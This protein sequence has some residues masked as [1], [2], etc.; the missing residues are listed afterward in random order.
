MSN[1]DLYKDLL[2]LPPSTK[3]LQIVHEDAMVATVYKITQDNGPEYILKICDRENDYFR[4]V[5]FLEYFANIIPISRI[6]EKVPPAQNVS[7]AILMEF[8]PGDLLKISNLTNDLAYTIG[9]CLAKIQQPATNLTPEPHH[10]F[11][12][13]FLEG[14]DE[15]RG[16][17]SD[18]LINKCLTFYK[19]HEDLLL[20]TDGPC[21][22]HR[23]FRPANMLVYNNKLQ[24][25]ID[26]SSA[27]VSF[28]ED[29]FCPIEHGEWP[30]FNKYK[31]AFLSGYSS[32]RPVP[33]YNA[34]MPLLRLNR[35]LAVIG[36]TVKRNTWNNI[37]SKPYQFNV[38][39][40][41]ILD[42]I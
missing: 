10:N 32:I 6:I 27:R 11:Q 4:E 15:C 42:T 20:N 7:G 22:I 26:W 41:E 33:N 21:I 19:S 5:Y 39:F 31:Q 29:D 14:I 23:D 9:C 1:I 35:A 12:A 40:L 18:E 28:S 2:G 38:R 13:K 36:F 34:I 17:L 3:F 16:H 25:I 37:N 30:D 24:G 8:L